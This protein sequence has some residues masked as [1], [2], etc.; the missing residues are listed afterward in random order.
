MRPPPWQPRLPPH[1]G[2]PLMQNLQS[3]S[4]PFLRASG[5][6]CHTI[7]LVHR[8]LRGHEL[9]GAQAHRRTGAHR[10]QRRASKPVTQRRAASRKAGA[11][12]FEAEEGRGEGSPTTH[13]PSRGNRG[14]SADAPHASIFVLQLVP[15]PAHEQCGAPRT[16]A[17]GTD[18]TTTLLQGTT[19]ISPRPI[20]PSSFTPSPSFF[21][22][23]NKPKHS[24]SAM[25]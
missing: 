3:P 11:A 10:A 1:S 7:R 22:Q 12:I 23:G 14:K 20:R 19:L 25:H 24:E 21:P 18:A 5:G 2:T 16:Q 4:P 17:V 9:N 6:R 15:V 8:A 13:A